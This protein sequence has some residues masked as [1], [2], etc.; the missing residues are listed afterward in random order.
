MKKLMLTSA[1]FENPTVK[2]AFLR[3]AGKEPSQLR[4]LWVPT[5]A[6]DEE[7][8]AVLAKCMQD[9]LG[10][11]IPA[12]NIMVYDLKEPM[13]FEK[14]RR[15]DAVY[16]CGGSPG[17]LMKRIRNM[18]F[19]GPLR[20]FVEAGGVYVGVSAGSIVAAGNLRTGLKMVDCALDV[21]CETGEQPGEID[22]SAR[23][24]LRLANRQALLVTEQGAEI[25]E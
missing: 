21:H 14:L 5:A 15:Y 4:A 24:R 1:G 12:A 2:A 7:A 19:A 13:P 8:R 6:V 20:R 9:L 17:R 3:L 16:F 10:A 23:P 11:G 25:I 22:L 18:H